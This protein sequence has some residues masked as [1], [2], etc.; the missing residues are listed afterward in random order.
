MFVKDTQTNRQLNIS[1]PVSIDK[2]IDQPFS[3]GPDSIGHVFAVS[4]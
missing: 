3:C 2:G 1:I 4:E